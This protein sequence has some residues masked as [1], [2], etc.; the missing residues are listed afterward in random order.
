MIRIARY[1]ALLLLTSCAA[2]VY[3]ACGVDCYD[4]RVSQAT[5]CAAVAG[6]EQAYQDVLGLS[7]DIPRDASGIALRVG[8]LPPH[9]L[10]RYERDGLGNVEITISPARLADLG[11]L[12]DTLTHELVHAV[13]AQIQDLPMREMQRHECPY[14]DSVDVSCLGTSIH[15]RAF[16]YALVD[17]E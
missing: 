6:V 4:D 2:P 16:D 11:R 5:T 7:V 8:D 12:V 1:G 17:A 3:T 9:T 14:Y 15:S 13:Q 10:G